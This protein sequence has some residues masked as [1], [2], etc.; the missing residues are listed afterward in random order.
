[1]VRTEDPGQQQ[2]EDYLKKRADNNAFWSARAA[3]YGGQISATASSS[4]VRSVTL[5]RLRK[6]VKNG[7]RTLE[8][9]CGNASSLLGPLS[10]CCQAYGADLTMEMLVLAKQHSAIRALVRSDACYLPFQDH[11]FDFVYTSRCII[12]VPTREMQRQALGEAFR[13]AKPDALVVFIENFEEPV[14]RMNLAKERFHAGPREIDRHNIHLNLNDTLRYA[15]E[16]GWHPASIRGNTL[17]S[18]VAQVLVPKFTPRRGSGL[19]QR[20]LHPFYVGLSYLDDWMGARLP[21][22]GKDIMV[23]LKRG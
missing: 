22:V 7:G 14:E 23:V 9:G 12:N 16:L 13:V 4:S 15:Q 17:V 8:I 2:S 11:S 18:L 5:R 19:V 20:L 10:R 21:L 6:I 1:M 3:Q